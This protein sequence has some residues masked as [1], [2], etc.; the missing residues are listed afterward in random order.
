MTKKKETTRGAKKFDVLYANFEKGIIEADNILDAQKSAH[1]Q[2][3]EKKT[4]V[5]FVKE[6]N[7]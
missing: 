6:I 7:E 1:K 5:T 2:A 4:L 3:A